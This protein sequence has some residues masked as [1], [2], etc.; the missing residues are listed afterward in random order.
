MRNRPFMGAADSRLIRLIG[1]TVLL[2]GCT[3]NVPAPVV[4]LS[5]GQTPLP[6]PVQSTERPAVV[7]APPARTSVLTQPVAPPGQAA[8]VT[9]PKPAASAKP[10]PPARASTYV[11]KPGDTL[12]GIARTAG[13][14]VDALARSNQIIDPAQLRVG[15]VLV[16]TDSPRAA[17]VAAPAPPAMAVAR[18]PKPAP[19][20][21]GPPGVWGW[22]ASGDIIQSFSAATKGIDIAGV[23]GE[24]VRAAADGKVAYS[25]NGVRGLGNLIILNHANGFISAY[26]HNRTL[27]VKAGQTVKRGTQIAEI[28]QTDTSSPRLHFEMRRQGTPVNPLQYLPKR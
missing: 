27:L 17:A 25:G 24:P 2:T 10:E 18:E 12:Y 5:V 21:A 26:A 20:T 16:L 23:P 14:G 15:Q 3:P 19:D 9:S 7:S 1:L 13:I 6:P 4:D 11:V 8:P 22:P 28:G